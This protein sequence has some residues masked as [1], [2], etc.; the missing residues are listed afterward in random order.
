MKNNKRPVSDDPTKCI[1]KNK[2]LM[3]YTHDIYQYVSDFFYHK[4][5]DFY[6]KVKKYGSP[7][8]DRGWYEWPCW[9]HDIIDIIDAE[10]QKYNK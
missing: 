1:Y 3:I 2:I 9:V 8:R 4:C 5:M 6:C 7:W 10:D